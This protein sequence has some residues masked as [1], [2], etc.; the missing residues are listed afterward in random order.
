MRSVIVFALLVAVGA[1][2]CLDQGA[3]SSDELTVAL[4]VAENGPGSYTFEAHRLAGADS[5]D[6]TLEWNLGDG[7][8]SSGPYARTSTVEHTY[9]ITDLTAMVSVLATD[10]NGRTG[11]ALEPVTL[12]TGKAIAPNIHVLPTTR[13]VQPGEQVTLDATTSNEPGANVQYEWVL[14]SYTPTESER[15]MMGSQFDMSAL[16]DMSKMAAAPTIDMMVPG[17]TSTGLMGP[18]QSHALTL[19]AEGVYYYVCHP[20]PW[21]QMKVVA[22]SEAA[23]ETVGVDMRNFAFSERVVNVR[24]GGSI[25]FTN[26]DPVE[27]TGSEQ[28]N[29]TGRIVSNGPILTQT[30]DE[31][32]YQAR[33]VVS[34]PKGGLNQQAFGLRASTDAPMRVHEEDHSQS[35]I[36]NLPPV[37]PQGP[38]QI[39]H[40]ANWTQ[41][42]TIRAAWASEPNQGTWKLSLEKDGV[43]LA[44][45]NPVNNECSFTLDVSPGTYALVA[46][47]EGTA[48]QAAVNITAT[49]I[50]YTNPGFGDTMPAGGHHH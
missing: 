21:M 12:G 32:L 2:G 47:V 11:F 34:D 23:E 49:A 25:N 37:Q 48:V 33:L 50:Q 27:H 14:G 28:F 38:I 4:R 1:A 5:A 16:H 31:G 9:A 18:G 26:R 17:P 8:F 46:T 22:T 42:L 20:H 43:A 10:A 3:T 41:N 13:W 39:E 15:T 6:V 36:N 19:P 35:G 29:A 30:L 24:P 44:A 40:K 45:C 7:N